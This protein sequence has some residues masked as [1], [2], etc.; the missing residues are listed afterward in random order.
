MREW[1]AAGLSPDLFAQVTLA[2][3]VIAL[4]GAALH[5]ARSAWTNAHYAR[6]AYHQPNDM[7]GEPGAAKPAGVNTAAE[8]VEAKAI[9]RAMSERKVD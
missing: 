9:M 1:I 8:V 2:E 6:F 3:Y 5:L 4:E 7:P